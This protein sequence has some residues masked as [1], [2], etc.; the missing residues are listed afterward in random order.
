MYQANIN[1]RGDEQLTPEQWQEAVETLEKNLGLEGHQR[2]VVEHEKEGRVHRHVVWNRVDVDTLRVADIGG[3]YYTHERTARELEERFGHQHTPSVHGQERGEGRPE[4]PP[5][6]WE[7]RAAERSSIDPK[8]LKAELTELWRQTGGGA[9]FANALEERGYILAKGDRRDFCVVD[10]AG[11]AH[12]LA[13]RLDGVKAKEVREGM[14]DIDR[15]ALPTVAEAR[16]IQHERHPDHEAVMQAWE[17]RE[18]EQAVNQ[19]MHDIGAPEPLAA[20]VTQER[21][22]EPRAVS[23]HELEDRVVDE[24]SHAGLMV[25]DVTS[26]VADTLTN[27]ISTLGSNVPLPPTKFPARPSDA[28]IEQRRAAAAL[29]RIR[30]SMERGENLR[31]SDLL[32]LTPNHLE[33]IRLRGD[34]YMRYLIERMQADREREDRYGRSMER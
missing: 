10:H 2:V 9:D 12:S 22:P 27:F 17:N 23:Y 21:P 15:E 24:A 18:V 1:P 7:Q 8:E 19:A 25:I 32:H 31:T 34:D 11:D 14:A 20:E 6:L 4:R 29:E 3:N 33:N 5:E 30:D 16:D 13:R 28:I 26:G